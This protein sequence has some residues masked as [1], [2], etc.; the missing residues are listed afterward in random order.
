MISKLL[1][2]A[3]LMWIESSKQQ[4]T[5]NS[6]TLDLNDGNCVLFKVFFIRSTLISYLW[7]VLFS[8]IRI[9]NRIRFAVSWVYYCVCSYTIQH[10]V[11]Q[12]IWAH[13]FRLHLKWLYIYSLIFLQLSRVLW[14]KRRQSFTWSNCLLL[15]NCLLQASPRTLNEF[16]VLIYSFFAMEQIK[17]ILTWNNQPCKG[18]CSNQ[19]KSLRYTSY[20]YKSM[21]KYKLKPQVISFTINIPS[22]QKYTYAFNAQRWKNISVKLE[23]RGSLRRYYV[24]EHWVS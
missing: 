11:K 18:T 9:Q 4:F 17:Y 3:C 21:W 5:G 23:A 15:S 20:F 1:D 13:D 19:M 12:N 24:A 10:T 16:T 14:L 8:L 6:E 22:R 7:L 2:L